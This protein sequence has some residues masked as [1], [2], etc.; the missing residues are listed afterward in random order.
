MTAKS[1]DIQKLKLLETDIQELIREATEARQNAYC[2]YSKFK[3]GAAVLSTDGTIFTGCNVENAAFTSGI[4]AEKCAYGKAVSEGKIKFRAVAVIA[5]QESFFTTPCG[6]CRQFMSEFGN[7]DV[8]VSKP[9]HQD[10]LVLTLDKLLPYQFELT[11]QT[12]I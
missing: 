7:V 1:T 11:N 10:V 6:S 12:F 4:C 2:P 5:Q 9:N 8:Y 3:V